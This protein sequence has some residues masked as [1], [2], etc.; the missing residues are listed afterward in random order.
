MESALRMC[1]IL[2]ISILKFLLELGR[3]IVAG[4]C[5]TGRCLEF[6]INITENVLKKVILDQ[7]TNNQKR[8]RLVKMKKGYKTHNSHHQT[9]NTFPFIK[10]PHII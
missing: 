10:H 4:G 7:K 3:I 1:D 9:L 2:K 6:I 5:S 8:S